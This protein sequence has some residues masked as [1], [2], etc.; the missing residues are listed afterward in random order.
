MRDFAMR[1]L[2]RFFWIAVAAI[3]LAEAWLWDHLEPVVARI[4]A[5]FPLRAIK[6]WLARA[7]AELPPS[8]SL[9]VFVIP[10]AV[11]F[12]LKVAGLW[13]L[14]HHHWVLALGMLAFAKLAGVGVTAFVFDLTRPKLLQLGWFR[15]MYGTV[16]R[17]RDWAHA[18]IDPYIAMLRERIAA[19][20]SRQAPMVLRFVQRLRR[21]ARSRL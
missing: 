17:W 15:A 10:L 2:S 11:L 12:P 5:A 18:L 6:D 7:I 1:A 16:M 21:Q 13:L 20:R 4:V 8:A 19:L 3:F 14:A 9:I